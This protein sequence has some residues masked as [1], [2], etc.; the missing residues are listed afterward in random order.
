MKRATV[1]LGV[2]L[3]LAGCGVGSDEPSGEATPE[4]VPTATAAAAS[5]SPAVTEAIGECKPLREPVTLVERWESVQ[6]SRGA[7]DHQA[8]LEAFEGA[9]ED[10]FDESEFGCPGHAELADLQEQAAMLSAAG[11]GAAAEANYG[12]VVEA[13]NIWLDAIEAPSLRFE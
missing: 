9:V 11:A 12:D 6:S 1:V 8:Q 13:G 5:P 10:W 7:P 2:A 3:L 4:P